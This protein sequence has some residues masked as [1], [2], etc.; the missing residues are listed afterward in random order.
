MV[1]FRTYFEGRIIMMAGSLVIK[2]EAK[3]A[4]KDDSSFWP[5]QLSEDGSFPESGALRK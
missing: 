3:R 1:R 2:C 4:E 5:E